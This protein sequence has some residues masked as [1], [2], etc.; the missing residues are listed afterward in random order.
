MQIEIT[1]TVDLDTT[2]HEGSTADMMDDV[3]E[4]IAMWAEE[5]CDTEDPLCLGGTLL[6]LETVSHAT[7]LVEP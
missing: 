6:R 5:I 7:T 1:L 3:E 2:L 4:S